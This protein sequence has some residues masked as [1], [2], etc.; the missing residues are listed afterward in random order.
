MEF[1]NY[2]LFIIRQRSSHQGPRS[3]SSSQSVNTKKE[4]L[5]QSNGRFS[6]FVNVCVFEMSILKKETGHLI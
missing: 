4:I 6:V 2:I 1:K 5:D 3:Q